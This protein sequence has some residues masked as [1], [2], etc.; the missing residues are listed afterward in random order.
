MI[1]QEIINQL[2]SEPKRIFLLDG[3]GALVSAFFLGIVLVKFESYFGM[4]KKE[5]YYLAGAACLFFIYD[6]VCYY[7][8]K[9]NWRRFV[10]GIAWINLMYCFVSLGLVIFNQEKIT[11]LGYVYFVIEIMIL[12]VM[13][14]IEFKA[15][16]SSLEKE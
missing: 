13:I 6:L 1:F 4:P 11:A 16:S 5:L 9:S 8:A 15:A 2:A 12:I 7:K 10:K 3:F 14:N